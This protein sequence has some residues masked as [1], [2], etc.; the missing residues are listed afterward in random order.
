MVAARGRDKMQ[1][2]SFEKAGGFG[3]VDEDVR[4]RDLDHALRIVAQRY[5]GI[6]SAHVRRDNATT[7]TL[8]GRT[9]YDCGKF[10]LVSE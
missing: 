5:T 7:F 2:F 3:T 10:T 9:G 6:R 1:N 4:A 8:L